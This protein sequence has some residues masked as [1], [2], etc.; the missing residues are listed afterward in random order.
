MVPYVIIVAPPGFK[1]CFHMP[2]GRM[3]STWKIQVE[4]KPS[5]YFLAEPFCKV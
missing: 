1:P 4:E 2:E 5:L 3:A